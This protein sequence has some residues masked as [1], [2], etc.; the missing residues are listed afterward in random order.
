MTYRSIDTDI[1]HDEGAFPDLSV[2]AKL[3]WM[4]LVLGPEMKSCGAVK[5]TRRMLAASI[6]PDFD[7]ERLEGALTELLEHTKLLREYDDGWLFV[8]KFMKHQ[9]HSPTY[10]VK[11]LRDAAR[12]PESLQKVIRREVEKQGGVPDDWDTPRTKKA[13]A[14]REEG[15][16]SPQGSP[17][18]Y[19][20]PVRAVSQS[21]GG[22]KSP[23]DD[24]EKE[25][26][27]SRASGR[28]SRLGGAEPADLDRYEEMAESESR[29]GV[30]EL[31]SIAELGG[32]LGDVARQRLS[33]VKA[34]ENEE[35][36]VRREMFGVDGGAA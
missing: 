27:K 19:G 29:S 16:P 28:P 33:T 18:P 21:Q 4:R 5:I 31:T 17:P 34:E 11:C 22:L 20:Y 9:G 15:I 24:K 8:P 7:L 30:D 36:D 13:A 6:A 1:W 12:L 35:P 2:E 25:D 10:R 26:G 3:V 14:S 23:P 32:V